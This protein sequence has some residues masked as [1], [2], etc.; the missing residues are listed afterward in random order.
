[1][2]ETYSKKE[3]HRVLFNLTP[4]L[5]RETLLN[6]NTYCEENELFSDGFYIFGESRIANSTLINATKNILNSTKGIE[7]EDSKGKKW[8][9]K[10]NTTEQR[11]SKF[12]ISRKKETYP[13]PDFSAF[14][15][16]KQLRLE[17]L[18]EA[19]ND[20]N[21]PNDKIAFWEKIISIR[22]LNDH[23]MEQLSHDLCET[24]SN[25]EKSIILD[26]ENG[27]FHLNHLVPQTTLYCD[28]LVGRF[29]QE[30]NIVEFAKSGMK[31]Y[32]SHSPHKDKIEQFL[33]NILLSSHSKITSEIPVTDLDESD[34]VSAYEYIELNGDI[35]SKIGAIEIGLRIINENPSLIP[36]I[37]RLVDFLKNEDT[38][39]SSSE[40]KLLSS[41]FIIIDAQLS[42]IRLLANFPPFYRRLVA[43]TQ[44]NLTVRAVKKTN[45]EITEFCDWATS[46]ISYRFYLQSLSDLRSAPK[47]KPDFV[48]PSQMKADF[49]GR[50]LFAANEN[51]DDI[52]DPDLQKL[53]FDQGN[54]SLYSICEF[55][56]P[57]FPGALEGD[58]KNKSPRPDEIMDL[59][60]KQLDGNNVQPSSFTIL[61]NA[62]FSV[63]VEDS[64]VKLATELLK[65]CESRL[66]NIE[67]DNELVNTLIGLS[68]VAAINRNKALSDE[69]RLLVRR[70]RDHNQYGFSM[71]IA[72]V[73][74]LVACA[75]LSQFDDWKDYVGEWLTEL[76]FTDMTKKEGIEFRSN[77]KIL[78]HITPELWFTCGRAEAALSAFNDI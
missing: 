34:L 17:F 23:E 1:M 24:P 32:F 74:C 3:I 2:L 16:D 29:N 66:K 28:R 35:T 33:Y 49:V 46:N 56:K 53:V 8:K 75:S 18:H 64:H 21:L 14:L 37:I 58:V 4:R 48:E 12:S 63:G 70:Y 78:L 7:I 54:E 15:P 25:F 77:L 42:H 60:Q 71:D 36:I 65:D 31:Q 47:W 5:I 11:A 59:I 9:F 50:I 26:I 45:I 10:F 43:L 19:A 52:I 39:S 6:D 73:I 30:K 76:A 13:A 67:D 69:I 41:L 27:T 20:V 62:I 40:I 61:S 72:V 22:S 68:Y 38:E 44:A 51:K 57:F 55:P